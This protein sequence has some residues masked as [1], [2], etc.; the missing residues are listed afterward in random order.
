MNPNLG[1]S[2]QIWTIYG[3]TAFSMNADR[4]GSEENWPG[5]MRVPI[6]WNCSALLM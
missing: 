3:C 5:D 2:T 1:L 6:Y 4:L